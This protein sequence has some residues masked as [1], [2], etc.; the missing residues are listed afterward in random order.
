MRKKII[1]ILVFIVLLSLGLKLSLRAQRYP[2][3]E[4][5]TYDYS[6]ELGRI[7]KKMSELSVQLDKGHSEILEKIN[8]ILV[9]QGKILTELEVVKIRASRK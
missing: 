9:N 3:G 5:I 6:E 7:E 2:Q 8:E 4:A 1:V